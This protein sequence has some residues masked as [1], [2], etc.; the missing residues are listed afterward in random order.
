MH[1]PQRIDGNKH[2]KSK[3]PYTYCWWSGL[4]YHL[5]HSRRL[6]C[7]T[8]TSNLTVN[9]GHDLHY[10]T[11]L[12]FFFTYTTCCLFIFIASFENKTSENSSVLLI[13]M[14]LKKTSRFFFVSVYTIW[15][16]KFGPIVTI[17]GGFSW[18]ILSSWYFE[19]LK[20]SE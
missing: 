15:T 5:T 8:R 12:F 10:S 13:M 16:R 9:L 17:T 3:T 19:G 7:L 1:C 6:V 4:R 14:S 2:L 18:E 11:L 20:F